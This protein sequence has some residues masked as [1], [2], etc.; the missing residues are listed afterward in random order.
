MGVLLLTFSVP[1]AFAKDG[2][3]EVHVE[4]T[5]TGAESTN[6]AS[7]E[8]Q[9]TVEVQTTNVANITNNVEVVSQTGGNDASY[10]TGNAT[11]TTGD[12]TTST[13][14]STTVNTQDIQVSCNT[15]DPTSVTV[16]NE[17]TG[18]GSTNEAS[19]Q[20]QNETTVEASN[21]ADV[22][23]TVTITQQTGGN[24]ASYN[25]GNGV[26]STGD[27]TST[28]AVQTTANQGSVAIGKESFQQASILSKNSGTGAFS[29]NTAQATSFTTIGLDMIHNANVEN[30]LKAEAITGENTANYNTGDGLITT[31]DIFARG[32]FKTFVNLYDVN[33]T[34]TFCDPQDISA[35]NKNTGF[36][37]TNIADP[38]LFFSFTLFEQKSMNVFNSAYLAGITGRN[39]ASFN[40]G[41]GSIWTGDVFIDFGIETKGNI[42]EIAIGGPEEEPTL[43]EEEENPPTEEEEQE[44]EKEK[45]V[46]LAEAAQTVKEVGGQVMAAAALP[47]TGQT[48]TIAL[49]LMSL[50]SFLVGKKLKDTRYLHAK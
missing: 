38:G 21:Y 27:V 14:V 18:A 20:T 47:V 44:E 42:N 28:I 43:P 11:I 9:N 37:S 45:G 34:C 17:N 40:T 29:T 10:N 32:S 46:I 39:D 22:T 4:N 41:R 31:G 50:L 36:S 23:N 24:T 16:V 48:H 49:L 1:V 12:S 25:T 33:V 13:S 19:A 15:C 7:Y 26:I 3:D 2:K 5:N 6:T 30:T 35:E 8:E